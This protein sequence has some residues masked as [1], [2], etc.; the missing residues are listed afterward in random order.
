MTSDSQRSETFLFSS[1]AL[2][3]HRT[4]VVR[5][6]LFVGKEKKEHLVLKK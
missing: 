2:K 6:F 1:D 5:S 4:H 3:W